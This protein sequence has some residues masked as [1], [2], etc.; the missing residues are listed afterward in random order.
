MDRAN[1]DENVIEAIGNEP[2]PEMVLMMEESVEQFF[3]HLGVGQ[4]RDLAGAKLEG[5]SNAELARRFDCS[6]RTIERRLH[7]IREKCQQ[8][9]VE[10]NEH[11]SRKITDRSPGTD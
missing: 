5:Y 10:L 1:D 6:E 9:L 7:L 4:L 3:S 2:T 8:E 11:P